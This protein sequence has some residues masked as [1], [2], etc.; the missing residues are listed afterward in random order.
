MLTM[1]LFRP[2]EQV[3]FRACQDQITRVVVMLPFFDVGLSVP[4]S[5][6]AIVPPHGS[7]ISG[8]GG[9]SVPALMFPI[10]GR[11][12]KTRPIVADQ[13]RLQH[14]GGPSHEVSKL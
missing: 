14:A 10:C 4:S 8:G 12:A 11:F 6:L 2:D 3:G 9:N 1:P 5:N 13:P 7:V